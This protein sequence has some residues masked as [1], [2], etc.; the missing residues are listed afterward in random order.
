MH[1][2]KAFLIKNLLQAVCFS[3]LSLFSLHIFAQEEAPKNPNFFY[4]DKG[5]LVTGWG[6]QVG[7]PSNWSTVI[8]DRTGKSQSGKIAVAPAKFKEDGDA[9]QLT[10]SKRKKDVATL[11][12]FGPTL[13]LASV[14]D[15]AQLAIDVRVDVRPD[16]AVTLGMGCTYPCKADV[17]IR[18][19]LTEF[20]RG[21]WFTLPIPLNCL[22]GEEFDLSK[23]S[24]PFTIGTDGKLTLTITN[25][26][27]ERMGENEKG[28]VKE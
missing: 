18:D 15:N 10:W 27:L 26:R 5:Q 1:V 28:C 2:A 20:P 21:E 14:K 13:N 12:I 7:D 16:K 19:L 8:Q 22:K 25:I 23:I 17:Q 11:S 4:L 6:I 9:I 3:A 24:V